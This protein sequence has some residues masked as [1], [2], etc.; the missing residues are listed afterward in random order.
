MD[1]HI[2]CSENYRAHFLQ[3]YNQCL[4]G[5]QTAKQLLYELEFHP[6]LYTPW[7]KHIHAETCT[8]YS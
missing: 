1:Q 8:R 3:K 6:F 4:E 5:L 7:Q 2:V